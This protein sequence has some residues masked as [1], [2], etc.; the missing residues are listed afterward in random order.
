[1]AVDKD[2]SRPTSMVRS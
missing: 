2:Q 1:M